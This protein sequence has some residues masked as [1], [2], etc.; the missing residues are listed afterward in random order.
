MLPMQSMP[1]SSQRRLSLS[2]RQLLQLGGISTLSLSL[3][4]FLRARAAQTTRGPHA[5]AGR[6]C[7]SIVLHGGP[8]QLDTF[9]LKPA[10][11][12]SIR[13]PYKPIATSVPGVQICELLPQL[14]RQADRYCLLRSMFNRS[15]LHDPAMNAYLT[16]QKAK[17]PQAPCLGSVVSKLCPASGG[18]PSYVW[19]MDMHA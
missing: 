11:P 12:D 15:N 3:P 17:D 16:G 6:S 14:C 5:G 13:G 1:A 4:E 7:I 10:A 2:R 9:D 18:L 8:S 19:L